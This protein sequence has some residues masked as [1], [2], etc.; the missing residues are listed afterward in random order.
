MMPAWSWAT[1]HPVVAAV[2]F[3]STVALTAR[4][5]RLRRPAGTSAAWLL[6]FL[7]VPYLAIPLFLVVGERKLRHVRQTS[8]GPLHRLEDLGATEILWLDRPELAF[9]DLVRRI[10]RAERSIH[11]ST[12]VL[13]DDEVGH[14]II[15]ALAARAREG[16]EVC[17][18]LDGL[19]AR[20][21]PRRALAALPPGCAY[22]LSWT[23]G[24]GELLP[25]ECAVLPH[26]TGKLV[27]TGQLGDVLKESIEIAIAVLRRSADR[28]GVSA[29]FRDGHDLHVHLPDGATKKEGPSA[30][31]AI[32]ITSAKRRRSLA[33]RA[34]LMKA[35]QTETGSARV[36]P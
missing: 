18:L 1:V 35:L 10:Q 27:V 29:G 8:V 19:F 12:Y 23:A 36:S 31:L 6:G 28:L 7:L 32:A 34:V 4:L 17:L 16:I 33:T 24:D 14:E 15:A 11:I 9:E 2:T 5:L 30:G 26:G 25:I 21:A 20:R 3:V 13:G 22:G